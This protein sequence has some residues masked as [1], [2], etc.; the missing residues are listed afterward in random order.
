MKIGAP[1]GG[2]MGASVGAPAGLVGTCDVE[3]VSRWRSKP[4]AGV[5]AFILRD[6]AGVAVRFKVGFGVSPSA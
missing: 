1:V 3:V 5:V 6:G 4:R 2:P